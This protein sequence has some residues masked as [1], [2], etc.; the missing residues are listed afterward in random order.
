MIIVTCNVFHLLATNKNEVNIFFSPLTTD[1]CRRIVSN[2]FNINFKFITVYPLPS[3]QTGL[4]LVYM[5]EQLAFV[6][7]RSV[8][9]LPY[10]TTC[11]LF[12]LLMF[13]KASDSWRGQQDSCGFMITTW[14]TLCQLGLP[15]GRKIWDFPGILVA[16]P[17]IRPHC[18]RLRKRTSFVTT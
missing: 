8:L 16:C 7:Q 12:S 3:I 2:R 18:P 5:S 1:A 14:P 15:D 10:E 17:V 11:P 6:V 9:P 4:L 13:L